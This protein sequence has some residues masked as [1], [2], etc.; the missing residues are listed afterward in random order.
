MTRIRIRMTA[1]VLTL[2]MA[3]VTPPAWAGPKRGDDVRQAMKSSLDADELYDQR[4]Y[5]EALANYA[6]VLELTRETPESRNLRK[7]AVVSALSVVIDSYRA[8]ANVDTVFAGRDLLRGY[9][10]SWVAAYGEGVPRER[11]V[12][13][14]A[15]EL[16]ALLDSVRNEELSRLRRVDA[17]FAAE[18]DAL[19]KRHRATGELPAL[20][21]AVDRFVRH[22]IASR[23]GQTGAAPLFPELDEK[24]RALRDVVET[25]GKIDCRPG[26]DHP[27]VIPPPTTSRTARA[28]IGTGV[29]G[30]GLSVASVPLLVVG[31]VSGRRHQSDYDAQKRAG[32]DVEVINETRSAG[33]SMNALAIV[34]ATAIGVFAVTGTVLLA[35]GLK[36][37]ST[38]LHVAPTVS[39]TFSGVHVGGRF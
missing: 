22:V 7:S 24:A 11:E 31:T 18:F 26:C 12:R 14:K 37:R 13:Q 9:E 38:D 15:E 2:A 23:T 39:S 20:M 33:Q 6:K 28:L 10:Q 32:A 8:D 17:A 21:S 3:A 36:R 25:A 27:P 34:G 1:A 19:V 5:R 4:K 16:R 30:L 35:A 29:A